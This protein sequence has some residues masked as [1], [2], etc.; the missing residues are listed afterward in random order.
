MLTLLLDNNDPKEKSPPDYWSIFYD[1]YVDNKTLTLIRKHARL[2][3]N[4]SKDMETWTQTPYDA[5]IH[6]INTET[7]FLLREYWLKYATYVDTERTH[8]Q[9]FKTQQ[10][11]NYDSV[12]PQFTSHELQSLARSFGPRLLNAMLVV[13]YHVNHFWKVGTVDKQPKGAELYA[14]PLAIYST[15]GNDRFSLHYRTNPLTGFHLDPAITAFDKNSLY[16][17]LQGTPREKTAQCAK[18]QFRLWCKA[19]QTLA[20]KT[21]DNKMARRIRL[22][23]VIA[24]AIQFCRALNQLRTTNSAD[25][26][27]YSRPWA[28]VPV[29]LNGPGFLGGGEGMPLSFNV[30]DAP[31]A[32]DVGTLNLLVAAV[33]LLER[34]AVSTLYTESQR[35]FPPANVAPNLLTDLLGGDITTICALLGIVPGPYVTGACTRATDEA[36]MDDHSPVLNRL[37]WKLATSVDATMDTVGVKLAFEPETLAKLLLDL[38]THIFTND[39]LNK[40]TQKLH[41]GKGN[42]RSIPPRY[43]LSGFAAFVAYLST[44]WHVD[45]SFIDHFNELILLQHRNLK[46]RSTVPDLFLQLDLFGVSTK[47]PYQDAIEAVLT[48]SPDHATLIRDSPPRITGIII[49]VPRRK[50]R[51]ISKLCVENNYH[52]NMI[53]Q[54][55]F[56]AKASTTHFSSLQPVFGGMSMATDSDIVTVERDPA[57]WFGSSDLQLCLYVPT[58]VLALADPKFVEI[59]VTMVPDPSIKM[60][61]ALLG[62]DLELFRVKF[63]NS[64]FVHLVESL[65]G[66]H[67]PLLTTTPSSPVMPLAPPSQVSPVFDPVNKTFTT[68]IKFQEE[69]HIEA[70]AS[71]QQVT[72]SRPSPCTIEIKCGE[73]KSLCRHPFPLS[74]DLP[75]IRIARKSGWI[76]VI[77]A[78]LPPQIA[79]LSPKNFLPVVYDKRYGL[80]T[81]NLP[82]INFAQL[83]RIG[84]SEYVEMVD[85]WLPNHWFSMYSTYE[86]PLL[87]HGKHGLLVEFKKSVMSLFEYIARSGGA[88]ACV[89]TLAPKESLLDGG[90]PMLFFSTGLYFDHNANTVVA[91]AY[92]VPM[93]A[94]QTLDPRFYPLMMKLAPTISTGVHQDVYILWKRLLPAMAE[95]CRD[96]EHTS[97]CEFAE[98]V[99]ETL[100]PDRSPLCSCGLGKVGKTFS[101]GIWKDASAF[102]TKI[103]ISPLFAIPY[104]E[105]SKGGPLCRTNKDKEKEKSAKTKSTVNGREKSPAKASNHTAQSTNNTAQPSNPP[106]ARVPTPVLVQDPTPPPISYPCNDCG[107]EGEKQC[108]RCGDAFYCS[109]ECQVR[110]WP[111]HKPACHKLRAQQ[112]T[113]S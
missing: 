67:S 36:Y 8:T 92:V 97:A 25:C 73:F 15:A 88:E 108:A 45:P 81:W 76:E 20:Q 111:K 86:V 43:S 89:F 105:V 93:T 18:M 31:M 3:V 85:A 113:A 98:G 80:T 74:A 41:I 63:M 77:A 5:I 49:T 109:R 14:S 75:R 95:R 101:Q 21:I 65:P 24:D 99:P 33:P 12:P 106:V 17:T 103:A 72:F 46:E 71:G 51:S 37:N 50:L 40:A 64:E 44:R 55:S 39:N 107:K 22:R 1:L 26:N 112:A 11:H 23:F 68:R 83:P 9:K 19:F 60:F 29:R 53:F 104:L 61:A 38:Y 62:P 30:I 94:T 59:S 100:D 2:L 91:E 110:D 7:L 102:V 58:Y 90:G 82:F 6:I 79:G 47:N 69:A 66:L 78:L 28:T 70:L 84:A 56:T 27:F 42:M 54:V 35:M 34:S 48:S 96:W 87:D 52:I 13:E 16:S 57:G 32:E 10:R 4:A